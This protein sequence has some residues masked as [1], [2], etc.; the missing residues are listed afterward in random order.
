MKAL[1]IVDLQNDFLPGGALPAPE[2][3]HII[4]VINALMERFPL[5]AASRDWHPESSIHFEKWPPHC[6]RGTEGAEFP[7]LFNK[8]K[9]DQVF[10]KGTGNS[11]DG[12]SAFEATSDDLASYLRR[13][14][15]DH[16][17]VCGLTTEYCVKATAL[18]A[19]KNGF[20]VTVLRDAVAGVSTHPGDEAK[21]YA[22][23]KEKGV[24]LAESTGLA[25]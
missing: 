15:V 7:E 3:N 24:H 11:D 6:I 16:L 23:M 19:L 17:F 21:A 13:K 8:D 14:R 4:A 10:L 18:D 9:L 5:V 20:T 12:Y 25:G 22:E 2:G 1:F